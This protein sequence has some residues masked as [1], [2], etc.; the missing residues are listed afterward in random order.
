[1]HEPF[2]IGFIV[3]VFGLGAGGATVVLKWED[4][5]YA[6]KGKKIAIFGERAVGKT[7]FHTYMRKRQPPN[8]T[9]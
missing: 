4:I 8:N 9:Q 6:L 1:M 2:T 7:T 5:I 3:F